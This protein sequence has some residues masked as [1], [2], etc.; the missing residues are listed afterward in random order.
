MKVKVCNAHRANYDRLLSLTTALFSFDLWRVFASVGLNVVWKSVCPSLRKAWAMPLSSM[1][2]LCVALNS[3]QNV[4][5]S[6]WSKIPSRS[7]EL[8]VSSVA[9]VWKARSVMVIVTRP[10]KGKFRLKMKAKDSA[11]THFIP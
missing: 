10:S 2:C 11:M 6:T 4:F 1:S 5:P 8:S 7:M 3:N 9:S